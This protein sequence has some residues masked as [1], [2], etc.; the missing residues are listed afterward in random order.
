M[1]FV[2][3]T[4]LFTIS[5]PWALT[6]QSWEVGIEGGPSI[7]LIN[8][9]NVQNEDERVGYHLGV[10]L[11]RAISNSLSIGL[12]FQYSAQGAINETLINQNPDLLVIWEY[13]FN[14]LNIPV[15]IRYRPHRLF[16]VYGG[17][18]TGFLVGLSTSKE[19][20]FSNTLDEP[21]K[22]NL[23]SQDFGFHMGLEINYEMLSVGVRRLKG[24][25]ELPDSRLANLLIENAENTTVQLYLAYT[26]FTKDRQ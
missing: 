26:L 12:Q 5:L 11:N 10:F 4:L 6:A 20:L 21:D 7:S 14:Y 24:L 22:N 15:T 17:I 16:E 13:N 1:K 2:R 23:S 9:A 19:G 18:Y 3:L 25:G 8:A